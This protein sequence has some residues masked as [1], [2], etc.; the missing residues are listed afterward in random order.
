MLLKHIQKCKLHLRHCCPAAAAV[1]ATA[2]PFKVLLLSRNCPEH[3]NLK[4]AADE[5]HSLAR[6]PSADNGQGQ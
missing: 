1:Q 4:S 3:S 2:S 6:G 5:G